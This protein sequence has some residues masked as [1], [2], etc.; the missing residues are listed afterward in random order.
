MDT[1]KKTDGLETYFENAYGWA[2]FPTVGKAGIIVGGAYGTGEVYKKGEV[3]VGTASLM[4]VSVGFQWGGQAFSEII[5]FENEAAFDHFTSGSF[6]F[7]ADARAVLIT[8]SAGAAA[9][10]TGSGSE[11]GMAAN[12]ALHVGSAGYHNGMA[13]FTI[14]L[15]GLMYEA[16]VGGQKFDYKPLAPTTAEAA[17]EASLTS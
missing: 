3:Q 17:T 6:E 7:S 11:A 5:F 12:N 4:Q 14:A 2:V 16:T 15:G 8:A 10:T 13:T 1:F 9:R